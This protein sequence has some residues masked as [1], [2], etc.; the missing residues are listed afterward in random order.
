MHVAP[1]IEAAEAAKIIE[2]TQRDVNVALINEFSII[3]NKMGLSATEVLKLAN[4]KWIPINFKPGLV[5][6][7]CI[8]FG[9]ILSKF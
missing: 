5:G 6:G 9:P 7:H 1:T 2:N 4:Q 8:V 3:C